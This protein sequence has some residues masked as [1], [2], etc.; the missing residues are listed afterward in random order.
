MGDRSRFVR[1]AGDEAAMSLLSPYGAESRRAV[2]CEPAWIFR[3][4]K[5][6]FLMAALRQPRSAGRNHRRGRPAH[7][8]GAGRH[9]VRPGKP[10]RLVVIVIIR[11]KGLEADA[12]AALA[13]WH[14][15]AGVKRTCGESRRMPHA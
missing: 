8:I 3:A 15:R 11:G 4:E 12:D 6:F 13:S 9:V 1:D 7:D 10:N 14:V 2:L 5:A